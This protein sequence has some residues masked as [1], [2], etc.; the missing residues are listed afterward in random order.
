MLRA[1]GGVGEVGLAPVG[2]IGL[3]DL[4]GEEEEVTGVAVDGMEMGVAVGG[5]VCH[6]TPC[7]CSP[8]PP[9]HSRSYPQR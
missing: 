7:L 1:K 4:E 3:L 9:P 6:R 5:W 8:L 2:V